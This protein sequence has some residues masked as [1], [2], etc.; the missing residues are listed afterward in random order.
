MCKLPNGEPRIYPCS[1]D[2]SQQPELESFCGHAARKWGKKSRTLVSDITSVRLKG[3]YLVILMTTISLDPPA[4][5]IE[6]QKVPVVEQ[7]RGAC[8]EFVEFC[9]EQHLNSR[10]EHT[11]LR[12]LHNKAWEAECAKIRQ[13]MS[14]EVDRLFE[15]AEKAL[16]SGANCKEVL[17]VLVKSL[18]EAENL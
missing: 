8:V 6:G 5:A 14:V 1:K 10:A 13:T 9:K 3:E 18:K 12:L 2:S 15:P 7:Q 16:K 11:F 4:A 17:A